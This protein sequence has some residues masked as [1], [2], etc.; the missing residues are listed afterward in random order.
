M[1][2]LSSNLHT[3][4]ASFYQP[5][6]RR[7]KILVEAKAFP[8]D[9]F[10][11]D[12]QARFH[13]FDPTT[14]VVELHPRSGATTIAQADIEQ[15]L[16]EQG[17]EIALV[18]LGGVQYYS[19]QL[20]DIPAIT[21]LAHAKGC[22]VGWDLA[23]AVGNVPLRLNT[24]GPDFA[25]WCTYKYLNSGPGNI[26]GCFVSE[27]H[28]DDTTLPRL[29]GWWSHRK[30]DRFDMDHKLMLTRGAL[31]WQHSNP[32]VL[33]LCALRASLDIFDLTNMD[34]LRAKSLMLT[35]YLER[36]LVQ[37]MPGRVQVSG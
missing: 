27:K 6:S 21:N 19:G 35:R 25:C 34:K 15:V 24:W 18:L 36:L 5:T 16:E 37:Q 9:K 7:H 33:G 4:M 26:G 23:H 31:S 12:S 11:V 17:D 30:E 29:D 8:S 1:N 2:T 32:S 14:A 3:M 13:G 10:V 28:F 20:F 22:H